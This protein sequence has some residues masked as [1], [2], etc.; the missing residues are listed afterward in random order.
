MARRE[1]GARPDDCD[2][3]DESTSLT[4]A[5]ESVAA[6]MC[7]MLTRLLQLQVV[8]S[9]SALLSIWSRGDLPVLILILLSCSGGSDPLRADRLVASSSS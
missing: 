1:R 6:D 4:L 8:C 9:R 3:R 2:G 7:S 5:I